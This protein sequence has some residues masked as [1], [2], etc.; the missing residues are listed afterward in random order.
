MRKPKYDTA[1]KVG[2]NERSKEIGRRSL[3]LMNRIG[4]SSCV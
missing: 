1:F 2:K 4:K 3:H